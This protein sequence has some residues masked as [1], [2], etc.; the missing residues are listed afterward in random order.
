MY[1]F[2][3]NKLDAERAAKMARLAEEQAKFPPT[4]SLLFLLYS[5][6]QSYNTVLITV[7]T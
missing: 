2:R 7:R 3:N 5:P 1:D 4:K 6:L